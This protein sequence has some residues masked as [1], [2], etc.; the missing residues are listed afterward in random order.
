MIKKFGV[1]GEV[2]KL[3]E[4]IEGIFGKK[5]VEK[6]LDKRKGLGRSRK[7]KERSNC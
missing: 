7:V 1:L 5:T 2:D 3:V 4:R 6:F